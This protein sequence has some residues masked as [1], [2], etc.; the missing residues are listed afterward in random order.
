MT[1][2]NFR[3]TV[4]FNLFRNTMR[5]CPGF[6]SQNP[7]QMRVFREFDSG[8]R[9]CD[10]LRPGRPRRSSASPPKRCF[11]RKSDACTGLFGCISS[12]SWALTPFRADFRPNSAPIRA[13]NGPRARNTARRASPGHA[14]RR[15]RR[16]NAVANGEFLAN[17]GLHH[18]GR[19]RRGW[20]R[21]RSRRDQRQ[22][23]KNHLRKINGSEHQ[24]AFLV[25]VAH[26]SGYASR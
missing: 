25:S 19:R 20:R 2:L 12:F 13:P 22:P 7:R 1:G 9:Q 17:L 16:S 18:D 5:R 11:V 15:A 26:M 3:Q 10:F 23:R 21:R 24:S 14:R 8:R 4:F 6:P